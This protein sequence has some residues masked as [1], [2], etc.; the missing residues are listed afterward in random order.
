MLQEIY[1]CLKQRGLVVTKREFSRNWLGKAHNY[2]ADTS[3]KA[4]HPK[5]IVHL[6]KRL[7]AAGQADLAAVLMRELFG[8]EFC[9]A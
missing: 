5:T 4:D 2:L 7:K 9:R 1:M 8:S 3:R 6:I